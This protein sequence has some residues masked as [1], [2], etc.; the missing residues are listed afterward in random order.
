MPARHQAQISAAGSSNGTGRFSRR[1]HLIHIAPSGQSIPEII[2]EI[3]TGTTIQSETSTRSMLHDE[4][5]PT[6]VRVIHR[7]C[8]SFSLIQCG[9]PT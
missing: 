1:F 3:T 4:D 9:V 6:T 5:E 7:A 8:Y 2:V